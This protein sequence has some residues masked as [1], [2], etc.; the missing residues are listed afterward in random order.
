MVVF[1][2]MGSGCEDQVEQQVL[3]VII[4]RH[5]VTSGEELL[6]WHISK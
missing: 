2:E 3:M 6:S 4:F 1:M 5:A